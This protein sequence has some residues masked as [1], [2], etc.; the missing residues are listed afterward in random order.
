[1]AA[2]DVLKYAKTA[3]DFG[4]SFQ[5][6]RIEIVRFVTF[7]QHVLTP[8]FEATRQTAVDDW[9]TIMFGGGVVIWYSR[10]LTLF[11]HDTS[12]VSR[13]FSEMSREGLTSLS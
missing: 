10:A 1:M 7:L 13:D 6:E 9:G 11:S 8:S 4:S 5:R 12:L 3:S 2:I